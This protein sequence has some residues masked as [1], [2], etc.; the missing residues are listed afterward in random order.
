MTTVTGH[1]THIQTEFARYLQRFQ[2]GLSCQLQQL[3]KGAVAFGLLQ[4]AVSDLTNRGGKLPLY[5]RSAVT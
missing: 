2:A 3:D 5:K 4:Q 1:D